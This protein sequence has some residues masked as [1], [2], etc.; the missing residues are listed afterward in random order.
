MLKTDILS[1][2][3]SFFGKFMYIEDKDVNLAMN[4]SDNKPNM[5]IIFVV[6]RTAPASGT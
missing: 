1:I 2:R 6:H 3:L 5:N 4:N